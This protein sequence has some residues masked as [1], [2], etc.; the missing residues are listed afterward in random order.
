MPAI[1]PLDPARRAEDRFWKAFRYFSSPRW[2]KLAR[3]PARAIRSELHQRRRGTS[4]APVYVGR[5]F[6]GHRFFGFPRDPVSRSVAGSG[7]FEPTLTL[8]LLRALSPG[9][10]FIDIGGHLGYFSQLAAFCVGERGRV[11]T[12]DP[13]LGTQAARDRNLRELRMVRQIRSAVGDGRAHARFFEFDPGTS[14]FSFVSYGASRLHS[15]DP[16]ARA[17]EVPVIS[18]DEF[19]REEGITPSLVKIDAEGSERTILAGA[20]GILAACRPTIAIEVGDIGVAPG[21]SAEI[22]RELQSLGYAAFE[23]TLSGLV[24]HQP[25]ASYAQAGNLVF[26]SAR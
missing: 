12:F 9:D 7:L 26:S 20:R 22:V 8:A 17:Y 11:L 13:S 10:V 23:P 1:D 24:A 3:N 18:L 25:R 19:C 15:G 21:H 16:P 4:D 14:A 6:I 5:T 2:L